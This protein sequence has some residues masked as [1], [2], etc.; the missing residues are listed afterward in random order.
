MGYGPVMSGVMRFRPLPAA[1]DRPAALPLAG[2][3]LGFAEIEVIARDARPGVIP[4]AA[5]EALYPE[6]GEIVARI[7]ARRAPIAGIALDRP[8]IMGIVNTT[9]DSFSDGGRLE[10]PGAAVAHALA[11]VDQGAE[12]LDIG[13][14]STR[15]GAAPV[16]ETEERERVIP[17]IAGLVARGC[18]VPIS[19]DTRKAGVAAAALEAGAVIVNDVSALT[20]DPD[21]ASVAAGAEGVCLMHALGDPQTMQADPRYDDVVL[22]VCDFL[23][24]RLAAAEAAGIDRARVLVDP[25]IGF[26]KTL[27][28]NL[29]LLRRLS[30]FHALGCAVLLGVSRKRFIGTLS[31]VE[32]AADR[33]AGSVAAALA[34]LAHGAQMLRVHDVAAT[35]EAVAVWRAIEGGET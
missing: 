20:H 7:A 30:L 13:G 15:P 4:V 9:P 29:A 18:P 24:D 28:H 19:I 2:G 11:L 12:I 21:M 23:E 25:G 34:G 8:R 27:A 35:A 10:D 31:G 6:A 32:R 33:V 5:A 1:I 22:D 14:E 16:P 3:P 17:V 26:G